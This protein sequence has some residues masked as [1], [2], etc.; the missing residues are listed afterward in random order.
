MTAV[1]LGMRDALDGP[2]EPPAIVREMDG[3]FSG[4][5]P[6]ELHLEPRPEET[7][8]VLRPWLLRGSGQ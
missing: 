6:I 1:S 8:V 7:W 3:W 5:D 4:N 2:A